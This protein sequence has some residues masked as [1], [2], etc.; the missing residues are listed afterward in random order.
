M[1]AAFDRREAGGV[2][3]TAELTYDRIIIRGQ[4]DGVQFV[5]YETLVVFSI[6]V[7]SKHW[8]TGVTSKDGGCSF[9]LFVNS[10]T[11]PPNHLGD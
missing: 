10:H 7:N 8:Y 4:A 5:L 2:P 6:N 3:N 11:A 1:A 9:V